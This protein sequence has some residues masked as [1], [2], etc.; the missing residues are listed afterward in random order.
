M[1]DPW[2]GAV[3]DAPATSR[4]VTLCHQLARKMQMDVRHAVA[5]EGDA[6]MVRN[7]NEEW[8]HKHECLAMV[9][10]KKGLVSMYCVR[11]YGSRTQTPRP[12]Q[13][14]WYATLLGALE[15]VRQRYDVEEA[16]WR[17]GG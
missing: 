1:K 16:T 9:S 15:A 4:W 14:Q 13:T 8:A 2:K 6:V 3:F 12:E 10:E 7:T 17:L 11:W 5:P